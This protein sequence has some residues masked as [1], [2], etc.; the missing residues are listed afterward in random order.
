MKCPRFYQ[1]GY[2]GFSRP[3]LRSAPQ[4]LRAPPRVL[5]LA[6]NL[7]PASTFL[8]RAGHVAF[9]HVAREDFHGVEAVILAAQVEREIGGGFAQRIKCGALCLDVGGVGELRERRK[10][11]EFH[12]VP[13]FL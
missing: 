5:E 6:A 12:L 2:E 11:S 8:R 9:G 1:R 13:L 4:H 3:H 10:L 7:D